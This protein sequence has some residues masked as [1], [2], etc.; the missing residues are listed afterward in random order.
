MRVISILLLAVALA[1]SSGCFGKDDPPV[2]TTPTNPTGGTSTTPTGPTGATPTNPTAPTTPTTPAKPA[3]MQLCAPSKD[4]SGQ[5]PPPP[6]ATGPATSA[7]ECGTVAAGY[8]SV[9]MEGNW[10]AATPLPANVQQSVAVV[11]LD[12]A[13]TAVVTCTGP[14]PGE[15]QAEVACAPQTGAISAGA[16]TLR[17][18]GSGSIQ[19]DGTVTIS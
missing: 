1:T 9:V 2:T 18:D 16:Y 13:G 4:F 5:L 14:T 8:T 10:S 11:L 12:A 17:Y 6:P 15:M 19:F 7:G 3:P